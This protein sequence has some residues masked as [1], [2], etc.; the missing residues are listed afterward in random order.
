MG[1]RVVYLILLRPMSQQQFNA[2]TDALGRLAP[3]GAKPQGAPPDKPQREEPQ[4]DTGGI[5]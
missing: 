1:R 3:S 4:Q 5:R 2:L